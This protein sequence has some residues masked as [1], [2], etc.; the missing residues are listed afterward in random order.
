[1]SNGCMRM[2]A[3]YDFLCEDYGVLPES[4]LFYGHSLGGAIAIELATCRKVAG[5]FL[6]STFTSMLEMSTTKP[7]Y[8]IFPINK[9]LHQ[10]FDSRHKIVHLH[11]P[12]FFCHGTLD[13]TIPS[14]MSER[15]WAI[16]NEPK[17]LEIIKQADHHNLAEVGRDQVVQGIEW[18]T[19]QL[20]RVP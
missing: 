7:I 6:E 18:L 9:L 19:T 14:F 4:L 3:G 1:M 13:Q 5:L 12:I 2:R 20:N 17:R 10:R 16:A 15:L 11:L 8:R